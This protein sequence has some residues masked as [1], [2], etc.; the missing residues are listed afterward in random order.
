[1]QNLQRRSSGIY[2]A[3]LTVPVR[4]LLNSVEI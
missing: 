1:M 4:L 2:V 3:R